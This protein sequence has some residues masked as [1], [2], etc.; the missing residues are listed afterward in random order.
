[1]LAKKILASL[2][3]FDSNESL[4]G[5]MLFTQKYL[6]GKKIELEQ[7]ILIG[8]ISSFFRGNDFLQGEKFEICIDHIP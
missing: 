2:D 8:T 4:N 6:C 7:Y 3:I 1:M 5:I